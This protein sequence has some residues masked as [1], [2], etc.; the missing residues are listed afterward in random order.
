MRGEDGLDMQTY[1]APF[2]L[3]AALS[4]TLVLLTLVGDMGARAP[5]GSA[6]QVPAATPGN[7]T[8]VLKGET[9]LIVLKRK[10]KPTGPHKRTAAGTVLT[11]TLGLPLRNKATLD[12]FVKNQVRSGHHMTNRQ[13]DGE[14][15]PTAQQVQAVKK[16][17]AANGLTTVY[18]SPD[19]LIIT[20]RGPTARVAAAFKV[21]ID[22]YRAPNRGV[23]YSN[24]RD[25]SVPASLSI[26]SVSGLNDYIQFHT[27]AAPRMPRA[28]RSRAENMRP[29]GYYPSDFRTAYDVAGHGYDGTGQTIGLTLWG[30]PVPDSDLSAFAGATGD[31]AM[32]AGSGADHVEWIPVDGSSTMTST[33]GETAMDVEY[34]H[35]MAPHAHLKFWLG[36]DNGASALEDAVAQAANDPSVHVVSNSWAACFPS[37]S[38][39][40]AFVQATTNS[41]EHAVAVGTTFYFSSGDDGSYTD[42]DPL[43]ESMSKPYYYPATSPYVVAVGGTTLQTNGDYN[44][45][46]EAVWASFGGGSSGGGCTTDFARPAWQVDVPVASCSGRAVPDI[47]ADADP[48]TGAYVYAG[49]KAQVVGGTSLSAPL[50]AGMAAVTDRYLTTV[51]KPLVGF[52]A[53]LIYQLATG[54]ASL[55]FHDVITG[56]NGFTAGPG[57]DEATGWGSW[58]WWLFTQSASTASLKS[59]G[60]AAADISS[61]DFPSVRPRTKRTAARDTRAPHG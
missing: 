30:V 20:M 14:F 26:Q 10:V 2:R 6:V 57:W 34:A 31:P 50:I 58:D 45:N 15:G 25:P 12:A 36:V 3:A 11:V 21:A 40:D 46:R 23:F 44:Y 51:K 24:D 18:V 7:A 16:W 38:V 43:C 52:A 28:A 47:A 59:T 9:P 54:A 35:G 5:A 13:F 53:P 48:A 41:F 32:A 39:K 8:T 1:G 55:D 49:G 29:G 19:N 4:L 27:L 61:P 17:G 60:T 42:S 37:P 22:D 56:S 33:L